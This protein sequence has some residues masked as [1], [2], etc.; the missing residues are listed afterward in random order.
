MI[1]LIDQNY[2]SSI[3]TALFQFLFKFTVAQAW[4]FAMW[5]TE[6]GGLLI[7]ALN[8]M[9]LYIISE[10]MYWWK[11]FKAKIR[12]CDAHLTPHSFNVSLILIFAT[13]LSFKAMPYTL[14][15]GITVYN[16]WSSSKSYDL[17]MFNFLNFKKYKN[18][19]KIK[20][21]LLSYLCT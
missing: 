19:S 5:L 11:S 4:R 6:K 20:T 2:D 17:T 7:E 8:S 13:L 3:K 21:D 16:F 9:M 10:R 12:V 18:H 14:F 1:V 15:K